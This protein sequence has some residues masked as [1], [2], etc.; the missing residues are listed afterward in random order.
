MKAQQLV[1]LLNRAM[2]ALETPG[3]LT[4][5]DKLCLIEDLEFAA[6]EYE[7]E[8]CEECG[9]IRDYDV[10]SQST[11]DSITCNRCAGRCPH[12]MFYTGAGACPMCEG[13]NNEYKE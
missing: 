10:I 2:A 5:Q 11:Q 12:G 9:D 7:P 4:H 13:S 1:E 3:D 8:P 6:R